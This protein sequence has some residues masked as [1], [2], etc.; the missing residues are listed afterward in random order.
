MTQ[1]LGSHRDF[2]IGHGEHEPNMGVPVYGG[3]WELNPATFR[4]LPTCSS[5][6]PGTMP[7]SVYNTS[8]NYK[9]SVG[10]PKLC[11]PAENNCANDTNH[12]M[13]SEPTSFVRPRILIR[14]SVG[15]SLVRWK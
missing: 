7:S 5:A 14:R 2:K 11:E 4:C 1:L 12:S 13:K 9:Q 6:R 3:R 10:R 8:T 15:E